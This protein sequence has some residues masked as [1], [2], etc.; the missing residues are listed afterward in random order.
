M[1]PPT[2]ETQLSAPSDS[3]S[4]PSSSPPPPLGSPAW[5]RLAALAIAG[6]AKL[7]QA[8]TGAELISEYALAAV[9]LAAFGV[10]MITGLSERL[11]RKR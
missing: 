8:F 6:A 11:S 2:D 10:P 5:E 4:S 1:Q 3:Q 7:Q 9:L